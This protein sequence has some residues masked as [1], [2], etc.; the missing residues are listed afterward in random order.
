MF[1]DSTLREIPKER[2]SLFAKLGMSFEIHSFDKAKIKIVQ[3]SNTGATSAPV[4][5]VG[6]VILCFDKCLKNAK[7]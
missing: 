1:R 2:K 6:T 5:K 3:T 4:K 7:C